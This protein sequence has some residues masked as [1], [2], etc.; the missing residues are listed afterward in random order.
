MRYKACSVKKGKKTYHYILDKETGNIQKECTKYLKHKAMQNRSENTII[1]IARI[2]PYYMDFL[3]IRSLTL[4]AVAAMKFADQSEHFHEFLTYVKS[5]AHSGSYL[6]IKNNTANVYLRT[7]FGLYN[8]L[9]RNGQLPFLTVLDVRNF[10]YV[11]SVG[12]K[13]TT[14]CLTYDGYLKKNEYKSRIASKD[15]IKK[16]LSVCTNSRDK[17]LI[18]LMEETG[19]RIGEAL[20]IKYTEDID[21]ENKRV[22]VR[23]RDDNKNRAYAKNAEERYMRISDDAFSLLNIYLAE[24]ADIF[25][26]TD[27]LFIVTSGKNK[28]TPLSIN[29]FYSTLKTLGKQS[30]VHITNHM[31]R[32]Y[33]ADERR[34]ANWPLI[35]ISK[36]LGHKNIATTERY[37]HVSD[38]EIEDAQDT[39]FKKNASGVNVSDFL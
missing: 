10:S 1:Q 22:F 26:K 20:G 2:L 37:L 25:E 24:H 5:G 32:H 27:Y 19:L 9:H 12:T 29:A 4:E 13:V 23:Y 39:Y 18:M 38:N 30:G 3:D 31:L 6:E 28:G 21:F 36:A 33:F 8:F 11:T 15:D 34:K 35:E 16:I 17:L 7:V 14:S